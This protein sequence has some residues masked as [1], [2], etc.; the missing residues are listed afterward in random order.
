MKYIYFVPHDDVY[1]VEFDGEKLLI[2]IICFKRELIQL[3]S[4]LVVLKSFSMLIILVFIFKVIILY[5]LHEK[6][7][8]LKIIT[9]HLML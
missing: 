2:G 5:F 6:Q 1:N 3:M 9:I 7:T 8:I 4:Q